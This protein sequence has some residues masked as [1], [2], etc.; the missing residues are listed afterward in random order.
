MVLVGAALLLVPRVWVGMSQLAPRLIAIYAGIG[1][2]VALHWLTFYASIKLSNASVAVIC[3]ALTPLFIAFVEPIVSRRRIDVREL[4]FALAVIPGVVLVVGG[5]PE[6]M[7]LGIIIGCLSSLL[8][9][10]F[11]ALNKRFVGTQDALTVTGIEMCAGALFLTLLGPLLPSAETPFVWPSLHDALLLA[12]LAV[13]CTLLPF[14]MWLVAQ[15]H[16]SVFSMGLVLN[17]EP[18]YSI[19]LAILLLGEQRELTAGFYLGVAIVLTVVFVHPWLT[20]RLNAA[21]AADP[22]DRGMTGSA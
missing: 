16:L 15:R 13:G 7:R 14:S 2:L 20:R 6:G 11:A 3:L 17:L 18:V 12:V 5:T 10:I 22:R 21:A 8:V 4:L 1:A 9:A 19:V